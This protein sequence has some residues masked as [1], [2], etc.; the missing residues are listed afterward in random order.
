MTALGVGICGAL[1]Q[2]SAVLASPSEPVELPREPRFEIL[3]RAMIDDVEQAYVRYPSGDLMVTGWLFVHPF[4]ASDV[5]PCLIFNHGGVGGVTEGTRAKARW[6]AK[7]GFVV[8]APSYR[9]EDDSEGEIEVAMGEVDD[10]IAA[11]DE[12]SLHPGV[13]SDR[14]VLVGSSHGALI[15]VKAAARPELCSRLR[16]VVAAYGVMDIYAWYQH[17]LDNEFDVSDPLS[18]RIYGDG[19]EDRP[20]AFADRHA[21]ALLDDL[22]AAPIFVVQGAR[23]VIVPEA[24]GR[25]LSSALAD[26]GRSG[27]RLEVYAQGEHGFLFWD[28]PEKRSPAQLAD[29]ERAWAD[30]L[31]FL[32][33][34]LGEDA[35]TTP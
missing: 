25:T 35:W 24:Q 29:T 12:L 2:A 7:Q 23:D 1:L 6:L 11:I 4:S 16:G 3:D 18:R 13:R 22:C 21:L 8:F 31:Q 19:P 14:F 15:S 27:D 9:G 28:D 30:I 33:T 26:R 32:R 17:L 5:E 10:V 34:A 20:Q